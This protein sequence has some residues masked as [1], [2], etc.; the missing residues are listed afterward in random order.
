M[1]TRAADD[2]LQRMP[3]TTAMSSTATSTPRDANPWSAASA[4]ISLHNG[5]DRR[6]PTNGVIARPANCDV[7]PEVEQ[8]QTL[9]TPASDTQATVTQVSN[10]TAPIVN[11]FA[12][13]DVDLL[14]LRFSSDSNLHTDDWITDFR[15]YIRVRK[16]PLDVDVSCASRYS[17]RICQG[18]HASG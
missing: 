2:Q 16:I 8:R 17:A 11:V 13:G 14:P 18:Q 4:L 9:P 12:G 5:N 1:A 10:N 6:M 7:H 15:A 3:Y